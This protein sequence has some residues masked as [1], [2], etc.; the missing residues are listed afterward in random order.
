MARIL[1]L[2]DLHVSAPGKLLA[3]VL[4]TQAIL[5]AAIDRLLARLDAIAPVDVVLVSG[6][7]SDDG[8]AESY[9][10]VREQL[11]RLGLPLLVLPGNH[12]ARDAL[13]SAFADLR[14]MP[15][16]GRIDWVADVGDTRIIGLDSLIEGQTGGRLREESLEFLAACVSENEAEAILIA[17]HHP[18]LRIGLRFMDEIALENTDALLSALAGCT[19]VK[20]IVAGHVHGAYHGM[21]GPY[22]VFTAPAV[23]F[24]FALDRR[25]A[26]PAAFMTGPT[27]CLLVDTGPGGVITPLPLDGFDGPYPL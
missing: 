27:G 2:S 15:G 7:L 18:P 25:E 4:D 1:Q 8:T 6:D 24:A 21:I 17:M 19:R 14:V 3:G 26:A 16:S 22:P 11:D 13:R 5:R 23:C 12:D 20:G 9:Q 10:F